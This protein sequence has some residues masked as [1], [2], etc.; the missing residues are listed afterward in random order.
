MNQTL[1]CFRS[2]RFRFDSEKSI[3]ALFA[4]YFVYTF[5]F[6]CIVVR[7]NA[8]LG[9]DQRRYYHHTSNHGENKGQTKVSVKKTRKSK[10]KIK[11]KRARDDLF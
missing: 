7:P 3:S 10:I 9:T 2:H 1:T 11:I 8:K 6:S 5:L 4:F